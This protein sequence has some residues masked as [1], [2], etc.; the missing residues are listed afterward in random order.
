MQTAAA[1]GLPHTRPRRRRQVSPALVRTISVIAFLTVWQIAGS[2][3][4]GLSIP[5]LSNTVRAWWKLALN[6]ELLQ[7]LAASLQATLLGFGLAGLFGMTAGLLTGWYQWLEES[8]D[9]YWSLLLVLPMMALA[10]I[11]IVVFGFSLAAR[12]IIF[13]L[14]AVVVIVVNTATGVRQVDHA[15]VDMARSFGA[16]G[17]QLFF[18]ILLPAAMPGAVAG[19]RLGLGRS[20][21]GMVAAEMLVSSVGMGNLVTHY[22]S[23]FEPEYVFAAVI[24]TV[25]VAIGV[26]HSMRL[27]ERRFVAW[28]T[29]DRG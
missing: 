1:Q 11:I 29:A 3:S 9:I 12:V 23:R 10:P 5:T 8:L 24:T 2:Y 21:A 28:K 16:N 15:L 17:R 19:L 26:M 27:L 4:D 22:A 6:G 20:F 25:A 13:F 14:F 18:R 7:A